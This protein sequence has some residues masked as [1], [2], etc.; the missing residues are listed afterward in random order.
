MSTK[1]SECSRS[2]RPKWNVFTMKF[3]SCYPTTTKV[4]NYAYTLRAFSS[5]NS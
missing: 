4:M 1:P 5:T 3:V 2:T